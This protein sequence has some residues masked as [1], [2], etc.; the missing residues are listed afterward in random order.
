MAQ[1]FQEGLI[2][3]VG[4]SNYGKTQVP[5]NAYWLRTL[6]WAAQ[7]LQRTHRV[8]SKYGI[9]LASNQIE[10]SLARTDP[11][12]NGTLELCRELNIAVI[13]YSPLA[14]GALTGKYSKEN[15]P[16]SIFR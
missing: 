11:E 10:F 16:S 3:A 15:P 4:V 8:L 7:Q 2:K 9:P 6:I 1:V 12:R 14:M 13:A 5:P